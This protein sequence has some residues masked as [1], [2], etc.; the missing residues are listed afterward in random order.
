MFAMPDAS[1]ATLFITDVQ[2]QELESFGRSQATGIV[3]APNQDEA[4]PHDSLAKE[5]IALQSSAKNIAVI[6][7]RNVPLP[8]QTLVE[9]LAYNLVRDGNTLVTSGGSS[10][11]NAAAIRGAM[12]ADATRLKVILP[13]TIGHQPSDVQDELIGVP[14][15]EEHPEWDKMTLA[16]ASRLCNRAIID[17]C[18]QLIL[19]L[20]HNSDTLKKA[21]AY[22]EENRKIVTCFYL[23]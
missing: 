22:A 15:I 2:N 5:L 10:G 21:M 9:G 20:F 6:G 19:F 1:I 13:Q 8:H 7:S 18:D 16:D 11:I 23:D 12:K 17:A 3:Q 4:D 14:N